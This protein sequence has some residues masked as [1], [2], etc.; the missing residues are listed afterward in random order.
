MKK[1]IIRMIG[2]L[3]CV[4]LL[5]SCVMI[6]ED[7]TRPRAR[8]YVDTYTTYYPYW[9]PYWYGWYGW[10]SHYYYPVYYNSTPRYTVN[11]G[12]R[13]TVTKRQL[14]AP[15]TTRAIVR[16][17]STSRRSVQ[18]QTTKKASGVIRGTSKGV[19]KTDVRRKK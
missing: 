12:I 1:L 13:R 11:D 4:L 8:V 7:Y 3:G 10:N 18:G 14:Q 15:K 16:P 9:T 5:S 2:I 17:R 6:M 19:S